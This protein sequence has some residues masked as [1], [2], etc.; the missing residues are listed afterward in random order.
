LT[1]SESLFFSLSGLS[2][3]EAWITFAILGIPVDSYLHDGH[4]FEHAEETG[5]AGRNFSVLLLKLKAGSDVVCAS[6]W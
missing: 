4:N 2:W 3:L 6:A 5:F 1:D